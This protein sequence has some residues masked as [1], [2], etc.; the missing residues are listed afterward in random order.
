MCKRTRTK[1]RPWIIALFA[2]YCIFWKSRKFWLS[3]AELTKYYLLKKRKSMSSHWHCYWQFNHDA[4]EKWCI[5]VHIQKCETAHGVWDGNLIDFD[6]FD[7]NSNTSNGFKGS[8][9][10]NQKWSTARNFNL[11]TKVVLSGNS[12]YNS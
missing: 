10:S 7:T 5:Y 8:H 4:V 6:I 11:T 1:E 9:N 12:N 3:F 2:Y